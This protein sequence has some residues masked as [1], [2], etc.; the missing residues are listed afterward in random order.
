MKYLNH[1]DLIAPYYEKII[2]SANIEE[3]IQIGNFP[4]EGFVLDIGGGTGRIA[5][6]LTNVQ[7]N[8]VLLDSSHSMLQVARVATSIYP[9]CGTAEQLPFRENFFERV[10]MIDSI[11]HFTNHR[12][13]INESW[14][15]LKPNGL[16]IIQEPDIE[17]WGGKAIAIFEKVLLMR[18]HL[19]SAGKIEELLKDKR[20]TS[21]VHKNQQSYWIV[22]QK[23]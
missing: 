4:I 6:K 9:L 17:Q 1:F 13:A 22:T 19:I 8:I 12:V 7:S 14:R 20:H 15:V 11:H 21:S 23:L 16:L 5:K 10:L 2:P 3:L 18:S